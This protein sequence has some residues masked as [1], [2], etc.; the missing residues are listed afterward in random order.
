MN[1]INLLWSTYPEWWPTRLVELLR[2]GRLSDRSAELLKA[3]L[4]K[5]FDLIYFRLVSA[6]DIWACGIC[7]LSIMSGMYPVFSA[8]D[9]VDS[10]KEICLICGSIGDD[11]IPTRL[12]RWTAPTQS[13]H[14]GTAQSLVDHAKLLNGFKSRDWRA[15][16]QQQGRAFPDELFSLLDR[17]LDVSPI[18]R[19]TAF[20]ALSHPFLSS[21]AVTE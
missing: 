20:E 1:L 14:S 7:L 3:H 12:M 16:C 21:E 18:S 6:T 8:G 4:L 10:L 13:R 15:L 5:V 11:A 17:L 2:R 9:D 19:P